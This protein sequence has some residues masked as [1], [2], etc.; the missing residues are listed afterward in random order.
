MSPGSSRREYRVYSSY[1]GWP[2][3]MRVRTRVASS[4]EA[5]LW[6]DSIRNT[7]EAGAASTTTTRAIRPISGARA[8]SVRSTGTAA[9][10][11]GAKAIRPPG[12]TAVVT[13]AIR[14]PTTSGKSR[15]V[16]TVRSTATTVSSRPRLTH[17]SG[18]RPTVNGRNHASAARAASHR[19][20]RPAP[21]APLRGSNRGT[22]RRDRTPQQ[23]RASSTDG[24][25]IH[26]VEGEMRD[27]AKYRS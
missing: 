9:A 5:R 17:G 15:R 3:P 4:I 12:V 10:R 21:S 23:S 18:R 7:A 22:T 14:R 26:A 2:P 20:R 8:R 11:N 13:A 24:S 6:S 27:Q 16:A 1:Q 19:T 25:R